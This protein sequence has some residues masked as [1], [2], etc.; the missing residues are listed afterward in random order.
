MDAR[1]L[2]AELLGY[3]LCDLDRTR[4]DALAFGIHLKVI[5]RKDGTTLVLFSRDFQELGKFFSDGYG[6]TGNRRFVAA[7]VG[8]ALKVIIRE[9]GQ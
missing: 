9:H 8:A 5:K 6:F 4:K 1:E 2:E 3:P 7:T